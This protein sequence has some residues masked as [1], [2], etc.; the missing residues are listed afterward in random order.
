[1]EAA[2]KKRWSVTVSDLQAYIYTEY[3]LRAMRGK[4][5]LSFFFEHYEFFGGATCPFGMA[6]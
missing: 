1:M 6:D 4:H 3:Q 2:V 5:L